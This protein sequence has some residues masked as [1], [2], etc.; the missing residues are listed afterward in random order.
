MR[1]FYDIVIIGSGFGGAVTA[2][3][4]ATKK[5]SVCVLERGKRWKKGDFPETL[6]GLRKS[7]GNYGLFDYKIFQDVDVLAGSGVGGTSLIY[8]GGLSKPPRNIFDD[9]WPQGINYDELLH[10]YNRVKTMLKPSPVPRQFPKTTLLNQAAE[11]IGHKSDWKL[12]ELAIH[13]GEEGVEC[14]DPYGNGVPQ[15]GCTFCGRCIIGCNNSS[16]NTLD[17]NYLKVAE[18]NGAE[19]FP[20]HEATKI[21]PVTGEYIVSYRN[22]KEGTEGAVFAK[23]V[24]L[25]AGSLG[26]TE[27]LLRCKH[28]YKTLPH[29]SDILGEHFSTNGN[30][31]VLL[32]KPGAASTFG[33]TVTAS[34]K[35]HE[36]FIIEDGGLPNLLFSLF[37][38]LYQDY[39]HSKEM[40][41]FIQRKIII[42]KYSQLFR[43]FP[44][45]SSLEVSIISRFMP[46][47]QLLTTGKK[48]V[49]KSI[50]LIQQGDN[51][52]RT[53]LVNQTTLSPVEDAFNR[54]ISCFLPLLIEGADAA[55]GKIQLKG[56]WLGSSKGRLD[57][58]W[59]NQKNTPFLE[60]ISDAVGKIAEALDGNVIFGLVANQKPITVHPLGGCAMGDTKE[61]G[62]VNQY[63]EVFDYKG[64]YV[65]D[66]AII[67]KSI[68]V[69]PAWTIAALAERISAHI[70]GG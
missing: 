3:R 70:A 57:I 44:I 14:F 22:V 12:T 45:L 30:F 20:L 16:K 31:L 5:M 26:S 48:L 67:P 8:S 27:L 13:W 60:E 56:S 58:R 59:D 10:F 7:F 21:Q 18:D 9:G 52:L 40:T 15:I 35:P 64:L 19:L 55:N 17:L 51:Q 53:R 39:Q 49:D 54:L 61:D 32:F 6:E 24:I 63:G 34:V 33:P 2:C 69:K 29:L 66:G 37:L 46:F 43:C 41:R 68:G 28:E 50:K 38:Q 42:S 65:A 23:R 25:A 36:R 1:K 62:V 4:L 11:C 47:L